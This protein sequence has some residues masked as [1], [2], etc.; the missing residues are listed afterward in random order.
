MAKLGYARVSSDT[1]DHAA[2]VEALIVATSDIEVPHVSG[3]T[4]CELGDI[5]TD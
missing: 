1:Q 5:L 4:G 3:S 2:Q